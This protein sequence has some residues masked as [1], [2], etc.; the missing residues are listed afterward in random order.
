VS[1]I[2]SGV[3]RRRLRAAKVTGAAPPQRHDAVYGG[4]ASDCVTSAFEL[5]RDRSDMMQR[6]RRSRFGRH[7]QH[8]S[9]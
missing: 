7:R 1:Y 9:I 2:K 4:R 3:A 6:N 5:M 8:I